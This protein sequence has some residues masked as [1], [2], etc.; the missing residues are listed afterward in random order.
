VIKM[1]NGKFMILSLFQL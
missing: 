1:G